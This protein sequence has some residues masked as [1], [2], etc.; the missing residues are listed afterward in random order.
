MSFLDFFRWLFIPAKDYVE[1]DKLSGWVRAELLREETFE[2]VGWSAS[3]LD[4]RFEEPHQ[5]ELPF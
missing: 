3:K 2:F 4:A 5:V 1:L